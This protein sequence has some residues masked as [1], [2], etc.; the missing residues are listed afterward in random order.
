M[1]ASGK[2]KKRGSGG[3]RTSLNIAAERA[4]NCLGYGVGR[5]KP[6]KQSQFKPGQSGNPAGRPKGSRN[7]KKMLYEFGEKEVQVSIQGKKQIISMN[8][9]AVQKIWDLGLKGNLKALQIICD[10]SEEYSEKMK[11]KT[12][13]TNEFEMQQARIMAGALLAVYDSQEEMDKTL[14]DI[15]EDPGLDR[16]VV[17]DGENDDD[18]NG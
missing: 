6:P 14:S 8:E 12:M 18:D 5:G 11:T 7:M 2:G 15:I 4:T 17:E 3:K 13:S 9:A 10:I 1:A 16:I